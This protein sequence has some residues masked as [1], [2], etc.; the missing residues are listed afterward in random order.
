M[1]NLTITGHENP[2]MTQKTPQENRQGVGVALLGRPAAGKSC[3]LAGLS[4]LTDADNQSPLTITP[5]NA[6]GMKL[7]NELRQRL[8]DGQWPDKTFQNQKFDV[9]VTK[10]GRKA[11]LTL[12][13][14]SGEAILDAAVKGGKDAAAEQVKEHF[15]DAE[16]LLI[17]LDPDS[18]FGPRASDAR[19]AAV[20]AVAENRTGAR[21]GR[22]AD[23]AII[24]SKA[25]RHPN[26]TDRKAAEQ[27]V[28]EKSPGLWN[29]LSESADSLAAFPIS[30]TGGQTADGSPP[31]DPRPT[32]YDEL[33]SWLLRRR[34][35]RAFWIKWGAAL[36]VASVL[37][38]VVFLGVGIAKARH[39]QNV[40]HA[41]ALL[42][43][44]ETTV[45]EAVEVADGLDDERV[46]R[47]LVAKLNENLSQLERELVRERSEE[48][49]GR[50]RDQLSAVSNV[51]SAS[52]RGRVET[53]LATA[54]KKLDDLVYERVSGAYGPPMLPG[55]ES[56]ADEYVNAAFANSGRKA[57]VSRWLKEL[58]DA[59]FED[60]RRVISALPK[61]SSED[62][63]RKAAAIDEHME[64]FSAKYS[65]TGR[66]KVRRAA[67]LARQFAGTH[68]YT[69]TLQNSGGLDQSRTHAI[70]VDVNGVRVHE[71]QSGG[72]LKSKTWNEEFKINWRVGQTIKIELYDYE[73][74]NETIARFDGSGPINLRILRGR[75]SPTR[76][77][78]GWRSRAPDVYV[79]CNV[80][81]LSESDW[82]VVSDYIYPGSKWD[83]SLS[84]NDE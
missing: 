61:S 4:L 34:S 14:A 12:L 5:Q 71:F 63:V 66:V 30:A 29:K 47:E 22:L 11:V 17:V 40:Q 72:R 83:R 80:E 8:Q 35:K 45:Q 9:A 7:F 37:G 70:F 18:D 43:D 69:V 26:L 51:K 57:E 1:S 23:V 6:E 3:F 46:Q 13:E 74:G 75:R 48:A 39:E 56:V 68:H 36:L 64:K 79:T 60:A 16:A 67:T 50:L 24:L 10:A 25:D 21:T 28:R 73:W 54:D 58:H 77:N 27:F 32:G 49:I 20:Q 52:I 44:P 55:F 33:F 82:E 2:S 53:L 76:W 38:M 62:M 31:T 19:V 81:D 41:F 65:E 84:G 15:G 42:S 78:E 59:R